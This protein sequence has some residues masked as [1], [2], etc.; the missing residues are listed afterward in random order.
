[1]QLLLCIDGISQSELIYLNFALANANENLGN[2]DEFFKYLHEANRLRKKELN[3][4]FETS[5]KL[6]SIIYEIFNE[7]VLLA[8]K[9][10]YKLKH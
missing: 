3:Y 8:L 6:F 5:Q 10:L 4:S 9:N 7:A 1:M 2:Q